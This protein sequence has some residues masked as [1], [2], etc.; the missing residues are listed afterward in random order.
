M[1]DA[2][3][4][5][6]RL[7]PD[8]VSASLL[9]A[10]RDGAVLAE[11]PVAT[12]EVTGA[13]TLQ[14]LQGV[15]TS[16]VVAAATDA[17]LHGAVLTRFGM[18]ITDLWISRRDGDVTLTPPASGKAALLGVCAKSLPPR[19][20]RVADRSD[21]VTVLRIVGRRATDIAE[22]AGLGVPAAARAEVTELD[23][24]AVSVGRPAGAAP[25][26]L[27]LTIPARG[28]ASLTDRLE[29]AG[30]VLGGVEALDLARLLAGWPALDAEVDAKTLPQEVRL[31]EVGSVSYTKGCYVG[32][33]TVARVHFR[34]HPNRHL[35]GLVFEA[36]PGTDAAAL[37]GDREAGRVTSVAW[38][39]AR[40]RWI[41]LAV[42]RRQVELGSTITA[43]GA[44]ARVVPVPF[45]LELA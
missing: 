5:P 30:V 36:E 16:D 37:S 14:C 12:L 21:E 22:A 34:G 31:D 42:L 23:E 17:F 4:I 35:R 45:A 7:G 19:L 10:V 26:G 18:I 1:V 6:V 2:S 27:Q 43:A 8:V 39:P 15:L 24:G 20:A 41:G 25:F 40:R 32:Q 9:E 28:R 11:P 29:R 33:E 13:G 38:I 44:A 3:T